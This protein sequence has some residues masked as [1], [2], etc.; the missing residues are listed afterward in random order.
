MAKRRKRYKK[1]IS[2]LQNT[3][4]HRKL[5]LSYTNTPKDR[6]LNQVLGEVSSSYRKHIY[7]LN[8]NTPPRWFN[9]IMSLNRDLVNAIKLIFAASPVSSRHSGRRQRLV[10]WRP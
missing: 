7:Y 10:D 6:G 8:Y 9:E 1:T 5:R 3:T 4:V 2:G